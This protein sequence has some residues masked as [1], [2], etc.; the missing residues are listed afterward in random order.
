[1]IEIKN[2]V[3]KVEFSYNYEEESNRFTKTEDAWIYD[4]N[5]EFD[6]RGCCIN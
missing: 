6:G 2:L 1:M 5:T 3:K 4:A